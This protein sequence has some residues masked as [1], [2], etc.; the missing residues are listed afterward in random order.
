MILLVGILLGVI[1]G[2]RF[3]FAVI[4]VGLIC[5]ASSILYFGALVGPWMITDLPY[6][7]AGYLLGALVR[8]YVGRRKE[9]RQE[10]RQLR[11][12]A[13]IDAFLKEAREAQLN[14]ED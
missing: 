8:R 12:E 14:A 2:F 3:R 5:A 7:I 10:R 4:S 6:A 9:A 1:G 13:K 11:A